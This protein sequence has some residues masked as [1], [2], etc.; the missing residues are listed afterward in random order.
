MSEAIKRESRTQRVLT[1][2]ILVLI[3]AHVGLSIIEVFYQPIFPWDAWLNWMYRAK[4]WYL[5]GEIAPMDPVTRWAGGDEPGNTYAVAGHHYPTLLP[6]MAHAVATLSGGWSE[7]VVNLPT[8]LAGVL[9]AVST[10]ALGRDF[11][12]GRLIAMIGAYL[13]LS[14]P[15][16]G[17]HL[18]LAG[19]ADIWM[20]LTCGTGFACLFV[21]L[22]R[23][24]PSRWMSGLALV[25]LSTQFKV[26]GMVWLLA[27]VLFVA[28]GLRPR[29]TLLT[30]AGIL[31]AL[32]ALWVTGIRQVDLPLLGPA[33][34]VDGRLYVPLLGNYALQQYELADDYL[35]NF[36]F[37]G[38]WNLL[39]YLTV[40]A[41]VAALL[42]SIKDR[43]AGLALAFFALAAGAQVL[44]FF[45]TEQGAWA[46]DWT[47]INRLPLHFVPALV[48]VSLACLLPHPEQDVVD[49]APLGHSA[50]VT[51]AAVSVTVLAAV[52]AVSVLRP[53]PGDLPL[54]RDGAQLRA[55]IGAG[56]PKDRG[57]AIRRFDNN[58]ALVSSGPISVDATSAPLARVSTSGENRNEA[59]FFWRSAGDGELYRKQ[60]AGLGELYVDLADE[61]DWK[62]RITEAGVVF[63]DDGGRVRVESL[64]LHRP[65]LITRLDQILSDWRWIAPWSQRSVHWVPG[66]N[67]QPFVA[68]PLALF[69]LG[70][71]GVVFVASRRRGRGRPGLALAGIFLALW[72]LGDLRWLGHR[73]VLAAA[74]M[75]DYSLLSSEPLALGDD[76]VGAATVMRAAC[77]LDPTA[78]A[79]SSAAAGRLVITSDSD[80]D[81]RFQVLRAKYHALPVPAHAHER[82]PASLPEGLADRVLVLKLRYGRDNAKTFSSTALARRLTRRSGERFRLGWESADAYL[83]VSEAVEDASCWA[84][85]S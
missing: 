52:A 28:L 34:I 41:L 29:L 44:I 1:I 56:E 12:F 19:Q 36:F 81:M 33:G 4:A 37:G 20:A 50:V 47:A 59:T 80:A 18:S 83:L 73:T 23:G 38:S 5:S 40:G 66:G 9:L 32:A 58:V 61:P 14:T 46:D 68:L 17:A 65:T 31:V 60:M 79:I 21:G 57:L 25:V 84:R 15:L 11:G 7:T 22:A 62:G 85:E 48:L 45:F 63:Y 78:D 82:S 16:I 39:W 55:M 49:P 64:S 76:A 26:E 77:D 3:A 54:H 13:V 43:V 71:P 74:A 42:R 10:Y 53:A 2:A 35:S 70:V 30:G 6:R 8:A 69:L 24:R 27:A 72:A 75:D 51:F 67:P